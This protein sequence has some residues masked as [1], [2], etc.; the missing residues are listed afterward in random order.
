[1]TN[2]G[3][4][5]LSLGKDLFYK[6]FFTEVSAFSSSDSAVAS[7]VA[8]SR[9]IKKIY[10]ISDISLLGSHFLRNRVFLT[11]YVARQ[12]R[13]L[14]AS[15]VNYNR[16]EN[17]TLQATN[18]ENKSLVFGFVCSFD[19]RVKALSNPHFFIFCFSMSQTFLEVFK[20]V[21]SN[22]FQ[23]RYEL[24]TCHNSA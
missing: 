14:E 10:Y 12:K 24:K 11:F 17:I 22:I 7:T 9:H 18:S 15:S 4:K 23:K 5:E 8:I 21:L 6:F 1:M 3:F 13:H 20:V 16:G 2:L 19:Y